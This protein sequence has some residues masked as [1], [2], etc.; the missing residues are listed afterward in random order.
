MNQPPEP[1]DPN[2]LTQP[3]PI[4]QQ[5]PP[6]RP[7]VPP[8][9][10]AHRFGNV[11]LYLFARLAARV[12]DL[13][14]IAFVLTSLGFSAFDHGMQTFA[15]R[16]Q[17]GFLVLGGGSLGIALLFAYLCESA[18]GTTLGK[19]TFA[20]H[21]RRADGGH[22]GGGRVLVRYLVLPLDLLLIGPIL[23][24][25]TRR[26]QRL[27]DL[28]AG[29]VV[30]GSS[31]GFFAPVVGIAVLAALSYAQIA[32]A[33]G[34]TSAIEVAAET[35]NVVPG[36]VTRAAEF[37]GLGSLRLP[38]LTVPGVPA[39]SPSPLV[40]TPVPAASSSATP[41]A[42]F[43]PTQAP[44]AIASDAPVAAPTET[45]AASASASTNVDRPG[46]PTDAPDESASGDPNAKPS[47]P[48]LSQ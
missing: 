8:P 16:D 27:G 22:A 40:Q 34:L 2:A 17:H 42:T 48:V 47:D 21:T 13:F 18:T 23:A 1:P 43:A 33:G 24:L 25:L 6:P 35:S 39:S 36:F 20:L 19:M 11:P 5:P 7:N 41:L 45:P 12:I 38:S 10:Y 15:G 29:T 3:I 14:A 9:P 31:M 46:Y 4:V 32:F 30:S 28:L 37:V 26:H 44:A